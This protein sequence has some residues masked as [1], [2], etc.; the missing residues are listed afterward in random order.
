MAW[1]K[2][3]GPHILDNKRIPRRMLKKPASHPLNHAVF[4]PSA[5]NLQDTLFAGDGPSPMQ[6]RSSKVDPHFTCHASRFTLPGINTRTVLADIFSILLR[7]RLEHGSQDTFSSGVVIE[8]GHLDEI[9]TKCL[10][11]TRTAV[12]AAGEQRIA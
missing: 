9:P 10:R 11:S 3:T 8:R 7:Q 1:W 5:L 12:F 6:G 4:H 2:C